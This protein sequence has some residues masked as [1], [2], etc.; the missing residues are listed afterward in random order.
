MKTILTCSALLVGAV[1]AEEYPKPAI[2]AIPQAKEEAAALFKKLKTEFDKEG[3]DKSPGH[4]ALLKEMKN[5]YAQLNRLK[6]LSSSMTKFPVETYGKMKASKK[7]CAE[8]ASYIK[9][10]EEQ[11]A[12]LNNWVNPATGVTGAM[13]KFKDRPKTWITGHDPQ[14][15]VDKSE[16]G[17]TAEFGTEEQ[18]KQLQ[19]WWYY[20]RIIDQQRRL[21]LENAKKLQGNPQQ[22]Q[23]R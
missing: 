16:P 8:L 19:K 15:G 14:K 9:L 4:Q 12:A 18:R 23:R 5:Y 10:S 21:Q 1:G 6:S 7:R 3:W 20:K 11:E 17:L 22:Q 2:S 13:A